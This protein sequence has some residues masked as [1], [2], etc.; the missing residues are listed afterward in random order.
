MSHLYKETEW[1]TA[2]GRW[3]CN[4]TTDL[5]ANGG[6][7]WVPA[8]M[9][10]I[11]LVDYV[12]LLIEKFQVDYIRYIQDADVL[13][14]WWKSQAAMRKY[15]NWINAEARKRNFYVGDKND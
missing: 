4:D 6:K 3:M 1:Q 9:L 2:T 15:K 12:K 10:Q 7:W 13:I 5:S 8:R 11:S 14:F